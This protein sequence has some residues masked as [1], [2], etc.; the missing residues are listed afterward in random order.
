M[1][2]KVFIAGASYLGR[3]LYGWITTDRAR[4]DIDVLGFVDDADI[5]LA[6]HG[7]DLPLCRPEEW[8]KHFADASFLVSVLMPKNRRAMVGKLLQAGAT[9]ASY[10]HS[11]VLIGRDAVIGEG[12]VLLPNT[13]VSAFTRLGRFV[14]ANPG[15]TIGH[16]NVLADYVTLLG[17]NTLNGLVTVD[18]D[19]VIGSRA[20]IH[21]GTHIGTGATVGIGSVVMGDVAAGSTVLGNPARKLPETVAART[22]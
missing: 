8:K 20:V 11:S 14:F 10:A 6:P 17:S 4:T 19:A 12:S 5:E 2:T 1:T 3:E 16:D 21:P 9:P 13:L 7:I 15:C 22:A 18:S